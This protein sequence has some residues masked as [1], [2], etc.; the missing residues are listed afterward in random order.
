MRSTASLLLT[1]NSHFMVRQR[2]RQAR[3]STR[4]GMALLPPQDLCQQSAGASEHSQEECIGGGGGVLF[5]LLDT[6]TRGGRRSEPAPPPTQTPRA[7][8]PGGP[9]GGSKSVGGLAPARPRERGR[10]R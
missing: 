1:P 2:P 6:R 3:V 5:L 9:G 8:G 7:P 4:F 10:A